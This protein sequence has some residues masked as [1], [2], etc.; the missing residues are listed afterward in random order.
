MVRDYGLISL[1]SVGFILSE[2]PSFW[3]VFTSGCPHQVLYWSQGSSPLVR[4][5]DAVDHHLLAMLLHVKPSVLLTSALAKEFVR[6]GVNQK[7]LL[8][9][10]TTTL[11]IYTGVSGRNRALHGVC[12]S[13]P[14]PI[15]QRL[16][17][18]SANEKQ[19]AK[20]HIIIN[21]KHPLNPP[22]S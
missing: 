9:K 3:E 17:P 4:A 19:M 6:G 5:A 12:A 11:W 13:S 7:Y 15:P 21:L 1:K 16:S 20:N 18:A 2:V 8:K 22:N 10:T 14:H